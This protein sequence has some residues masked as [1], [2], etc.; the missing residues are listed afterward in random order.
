MDETWTDIPYG[1]GSGV[2][3]EGDQGWEWH[4]KPHPMGTFN[5]GP[6]K[7]GAQKDDRLKKEEKIKVRNM[8]EKEMQRQGKKGVGERR[9]KPSNKPHSCDNLVWREGQ[10]RTDGC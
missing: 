9:S 6:W 10:L 4:P 1:M 8:A 5:P 2:H 7:R 3:K